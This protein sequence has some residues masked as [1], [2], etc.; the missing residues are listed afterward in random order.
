[1]NNKKYTPNTKKELFRLLDN[2]K[3]NLGDINTSHISDMSEL[4]CTAQEVILVALNLGTLRML[5]V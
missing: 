4:F 1:M 5:Q 2:P 3:I